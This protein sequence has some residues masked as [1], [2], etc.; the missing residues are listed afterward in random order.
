[1]HADGGPLPKGW[2]AL[3]RW[4]A[5]PWK[6]NALYPIAA[7]AG[8]MSTQVRPRHAAPAG[9]IG[10]TR[11]MAYTRPRRVLPQ[12]Q[13]RSEATIEANRDSRNVEMAH[14]PVIGIESG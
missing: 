12:N 14:R 9:A 7:F 1:V 2:S 6:I 10:T 8:G 4:P 11:A 3:Y 13:A 5:K